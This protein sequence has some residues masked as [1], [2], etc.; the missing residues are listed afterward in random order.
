MRE[1][2]GNEKRTSELLFCNKEYTKHHINS[3]T[4]ESRSYMKIT[5][6]KQNDKCSNKN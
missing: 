4:Q 1:D 6:A 2:G 3:R 5:L